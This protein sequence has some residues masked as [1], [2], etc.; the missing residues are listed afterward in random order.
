MSSGKTPVAIPYK[1]PA[2]PVN[3]RA[4][5]AGAPLA[6]TE[7][8]PLYSDAWIT[9]QIDHGLGPYEFI[10]AY[11][12]VEAYEAHIR[13]SV[14][15]RISWHLPPGALAQKLGTTNAGSY[16]GGGVE[17]ELAALL[18]LCLGIRARAGGPSRYFGPGVDPR[19]TLQPGMHK[20]IHQIPLPRLRRRLL[21]F[22][23]G[24]HTLG[25]A[26]TLPLTRLY[27]LSERD[28]ADLVKAARLHQEAMWIAE[29]SPGV[30]WILLVTAVETCA[31]NW[32]GR[33]H[34]R[35]RA[36]RRFAEFLL[37]FSPS[38]P[39]DRPEPCYQLGWDAVSLAAAVEKIYEWRCAF[40]H[41]GIHFPQPMCEPPYREDKDGPYSEI[42]IGM[43]TAV[44]GG[45]WPVSETPILLHTFEYMVRGAI[46]KWWQWCL[47]SVPYLNSAG[48][49]TLGRIPGIGDRL[50]GRIARDRRIRG[51]F[52]SFGDLARIKGVGAKAMNAIEQHTTLVMK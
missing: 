9:G 48:E 46:L 3:W 38:P 18:G 51:A 28:A 33:A 45:T 50:A 19:G 26:L 25:D 27:T 7:E 34:P 5:R 4:A 39:A 17:D 14:V 31:Q 47:P 16:H 49:A 13:P 43:A 42:P 12:N 52:S 2:S 32:A 8:Y 37:T 30:A 41:E 22:A 20:P 10:N 44:P 40:V 6:W 11:G 15:I 24:T 21:P 29:G 35:W 36:T 1:W 23:S